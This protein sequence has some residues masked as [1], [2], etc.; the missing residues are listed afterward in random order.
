MLFIDNI[1]PSLSLQLL[2]AYLL[3]CESP[4]ED[5]QALPKNPGKEW[6]PG[7]NLKKLGVSPVTH[8]SGTIEAEN[9]TFEVQCSYDF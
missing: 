4:A 3:N 5:S 6:G 8:E 1:V 2:C 9:G 7:E